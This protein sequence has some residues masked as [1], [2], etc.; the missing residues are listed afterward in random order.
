M[1]RFGYACKVLGVP[2]TDTRTCTLKYATPEKLLEI[3]RYNLAAL[4]RMVQY[5]RAQQIGLL[6]LSSDVIP[7]ASHPH[8]Q[9]DW[10]NLCGPE[11][12]ALAQS[13]E[14]QSIEAQNIEAQ[15]IESQGA[16]NQAKQHGH[17]GMPASFMKNAA[18]GAAYNLDD[19]ADN[20]PDNGPDNGAGSEAGSGLGSG[21]SSGPDNGAGSGAA[22]EASSGASSGVSNGVSSGAGST[23]N[24]AKGCNYPLRVSMH[25][26]QYTVLNSPH[27]QVVERAMAD[28]LF[29]AQFLDALAVPQSA[30]IILHVGGVYDD[31]KAALKRFKI[32]FEK[33]PE[34]VVRRLI[35]ENDERCYAI[36]E[37][38]ALCESLQ[39]PAIFD[40]FHHSI[41]A[42]NQGTTLSWL[43][44]SGKTW[45]EQDG[46][47]KIHYSQQLPKGKPGSHS[48][49]IA[50]ADFLTFYQQIQN[51][52]LDIMLEVKDKN[53]SAIK[54][55]NLCTQNLPRRALTDE[56]A[57][58]K[59]TV[60]EKSPSHYQQFRNYL[61]ADNPDALGFYK[62]LEQALA[63]PLTPGNALN[64][65]Q[66]VWGYLDELATPA[67]K[68]KV[69]EKFQI[70]KTSLLPLPSLKKQFYTLAQQQKQ[71]YL[72]QSLYF[73]PV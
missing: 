69:L 41:L 71:T 47:Q 28:L 52:N 33:L 24:K 8:I 22:S 51:L 35:L 12:E 29:H 13:I 50:S 7:L 30:K 66:H 45:K 32:A 63:Q 57:R 70:L 10:Q 17:L 6:R 39:V 61:K 14:G 67:E 11:L 40:V 73:Y 56:W 26:G 49:S 53:L 34:C 3:S 21:A 54:C 5:T 68:K 9:F 42:P 20:G 19:R 64:A 72:L 60:L 46:T 15:N 31:K 58:Y 4:Q 16:S 43:L 25:P 65:A 2:E 37:V 44:E 23:R 48:L 27:P 38:L 18:S 1:I 36:D 62:L 59:Y 55:Q